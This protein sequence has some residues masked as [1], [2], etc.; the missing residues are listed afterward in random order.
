MKVQNKESL[1]AR[2]KRVIIPGRGIRLND[3]HGELKVT[4]WNVKTLYKDGKLEN[5]V[6]EMR[7][8][9]WDILGVSEVRCIECGDVPSYDSTHFYYSGGKKHRFGVGFI[10][11]IEVREC[12]TGYVPR[13]DRVMLL[14]LNTKPIKTNL[15]QVY[16]P[17][18]E[19]TEAEC[20]N[21][22]KDLEKKERK[23]KKRK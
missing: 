6:R 14:Q 1:S 17:T 20:E 13:S 16:A 12:V 23:K 8:Y 3:D 7:R 2:Q 4:T 19:S 10:V 9:R 18:S 5:A 22:Y 15:I 21:F 11:T